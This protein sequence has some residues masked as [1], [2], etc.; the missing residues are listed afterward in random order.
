MRILIDILHPAHVHFFRNFAQEM[1]M[2]GHEIRFTAR[3]KECATD[4]LDHYGIPYTLLSRQK[5]G[6]ALASELAR[7]AAE[8]GARYDIG[9]FVRKMERLYE[10][11][12]R[13]SRATRRAGVLS[14]DLGFLTARG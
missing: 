4:L 3:A 14:A 9:A 11:L 8:T 12:H 13:T 10:I 1:R 2:R 6:L 7:H 5:S